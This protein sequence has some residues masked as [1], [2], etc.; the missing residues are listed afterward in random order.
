VSRYKTLWQSNWDTPLSYRD[1]QYELQYTEAKGLGFETGVGRRDPSGVIKIG[2]LYYVWYTYFKDM[3]PPVGFEKADETSRAVT[4]DLC[5]I[6]YATSPDGVNWTEKGEAVPLGPKGQF[7]DRSVFTPDILVAEGKYYLFY[8]AVSFPYTQRTQNVI[9]M[10]WADSPDGPWHRHPKPILTT[11]EPGQWVDPSLILPEERKNFGWPITKKSD[12]DGHKIHDPTLIVRGGKYH[13]YYKGQ[14][15]GKSQRLPPG[16][17]CADKELGVP[18]S[19]GV[20]IADRPEGPYVKS[21]LNPVVVAGHESIFWPHGTGVA[22]LMVQGPE[23]G[24]IQYA[25]DGVNFY[26]MATVDEWP[27]AA[28]LYRPGCFADILKRPGE[29]A[30]W[31]IC[32]MLRYGKNNFWPGL[33]RVDFV[34]KKHDF[35]PKFHRH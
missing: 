23:A 33:E 15:F 34:K 22:C 8:Q 4:W 6:W 2:G 7:D 25:P 3:N 32:H 35:K 14:P 9:G 28:G 11:G 17:R 29:G 19:Q 27:E 16:E 30:T 10:S 13:L 12:W 1:F 5:T 24:T 31:G 20:A 18:I 26:V 21:P